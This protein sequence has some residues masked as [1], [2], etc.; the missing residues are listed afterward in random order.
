MHS[1]WEGLEREITAGYILFLDLGSGKKCAFILS[2]SV[3]LYT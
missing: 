2:K 1:S 3:K